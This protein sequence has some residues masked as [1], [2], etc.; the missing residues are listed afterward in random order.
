MFLF[1]LVPSRLAPRSFAEG[2]AAR[3]ADRRSIG[4]EEFGRDA[5]AVT[6]PLLGD[7]CGTLNCS[8][9]CFKVS[10]D[11]THTPLAVMISAGW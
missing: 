5:D 6:I 3:F 4:D 2:G 11:C 8:R 7:R 10:V 1:I 9:A